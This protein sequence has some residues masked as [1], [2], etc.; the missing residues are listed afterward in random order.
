M[1]KLTNEKR[2]A[3]EWIDEHTRRFS[4]FHSRVWSYAEPAWR[5]YKSAKAYCDLLRAE[6]FAVEESSG[7]M[8]TAFAARWGKSGPVLGGF[9]VF[10]LILSWS[11]P[12]LSGVALVLIGAASGIA[13]FLDR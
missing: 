1:A 12:A 8:P 6:G 11:A 10:Y 5:E 4:E 2:Y 3:F 9:G 13:Y 7:E